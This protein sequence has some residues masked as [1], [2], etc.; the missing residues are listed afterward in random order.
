MPIPDFQSIML[1]LLSLA[2]DGCVRTLVEVRGQLQKEFQLS[3]GEIEEMLPSGRQ[4]KF[5]N[6]VAWAK[7]YLEQAGLLVSPQRGRFQ[8]T[9]EGLRL[10]ES[11]PPVISIATLE[12]YEPFRIFRLRSKSSKKNET[13]LVGAE[14]GQT[15]EEELEQA[16]ANITAELALTLLDQ[17]KAASP[18]FFERL[19]VE[20]LLKMGYG[21]N[22]AEA[23][24]AIGKSGDEGIDGIISEDRL[25]LETIYIQAKRWTGTVGRPEI[26]K[27]VGALVGKRSRKGVFLTTGAF[28]A[29]ARE[30][31]ANIESRVVLVDG[32]Q[33]ADY[34]IE[35]NLGVATKAVYE[36]KRIDTD[37][38]IE[39]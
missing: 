7:V 13:T 11:K 1:P 23:G 36:I 19:V 6:R 18:G 38:F 12:Q 3:S 32:A 9:A 15:P 4:R 2:G 27:F 35:H 20:L 31:A 26:Q 34:M 5:N 14:A 24:Q 29:E 22:R 37:F 17:V 25:G 21:R 30:Y 39:E 28:S 8:I 33:L 16:Y 10:L